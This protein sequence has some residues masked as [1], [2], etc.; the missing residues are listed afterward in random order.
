MIKNRYTFR[1]TAAALFKSHPL[2]SRVVTCGGK[3]GADW[4][5]SLTTVDTAR[6]QD[7][8]GWWKFRFPSPRNHESQRGGGGAEAKSAGKRE[9]T[10]DRRPLCVITNHPARTVLFNRAKVQERSTFAS[11]PFFSTHPPPPPPPRWSASGMRGEK[12][13]RARLKRG[14][15]KRRDPA[16]MSKYL[17]E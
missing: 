12:K 13:R 15:A 10:R 8:G 6:P 1:P 14:R 3:V 11:N 16:W 5:G 17:S 4:Y 7:N 9:V 2:N